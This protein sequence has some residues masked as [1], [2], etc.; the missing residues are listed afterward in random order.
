MLIPTDWLPLTIRSFEEGDRFA[1]DSA[2]H[3]K[4][5]ARYFIDKKIPKEI[6]S[7]VPIVLNKQGEIVW[8]VG[9]RKSYLSIVPE[10]DKIFYKLTYYKK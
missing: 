7:Q 9:F 10:T 3:T 4:K 8:I 2:G 5:V 6:R 1:L